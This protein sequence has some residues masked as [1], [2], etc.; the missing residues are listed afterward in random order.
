MYRIPRSSFL[1][2]V[3]AASLTP[4]VAAAAQFLAGKTALVL[5]GGGALGAYEA[6]VVAGL[7]RR[8]FRA[9]VVCGT[10]IGAINAALY[11]QGD[12][13]R[14]I[15]LWKSMPGRKI[16]KP[17][18]I[19]SE[20]WQFVRD[21]VFGSSTAPVTI[22]PALVRTGRDLRDLFPLGILDDGPVKELLRDSL[23]LSRVGT[24]LAIG[25]T[26]VSLSR[27]EAFLVPLNLAPP[28]TP[29]RS[30]IHLITDEHHFAWAVQASGALPLIFPPVQIDVLERTGS[31][32][33]SYVDGG[34]ASNTPVALARL[35]GATNIVCILLSPRAPTLQPLL[36][37]LDLM[38][39][40]WAAN[41]Q[42]L[43]EEEFRDI[44]YSVRR[45]PRH[46]SSK[47]ARRDRLA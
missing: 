14:L 10:S 41:Q 17:A 15:R 40:F 16:L 42:R 18:P 35:L 32:T 37:P 28:P 5:S 38:S 20:L 12:G 43:L 23:D 34:A 3:A 29:V 1:G 25:V 31:A 39:S 13:E 9:D 46:G 45:P 36:S 19:L 4:S 44:E 30:P 7:L 2:A 6:G 47:F 11:A 22:D 26:N 33:Y 8:G 24:P 21:T 27:T